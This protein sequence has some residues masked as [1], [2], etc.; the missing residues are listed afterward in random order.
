MKRTPTEICGLSRPRRRVESGADKA[1]GLS[2]PHAAPPSRGG[3]LGLIR[4]FRKVLTS[5]SR[6]RIV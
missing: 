3:V 1:G 2:G 4:R 6:G 5:P